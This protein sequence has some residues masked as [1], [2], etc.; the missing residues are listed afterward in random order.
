MY[1]RGPRLMKQVNVILA[2]MA[3]KP[4]IGS[5]YP[6]MGLRPTLLLA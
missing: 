2:V 1:N 6:R 3:D 4:S 5:D